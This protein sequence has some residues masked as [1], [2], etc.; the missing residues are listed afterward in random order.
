VTKVEQHDLANLD[1]SFAGLLRI[2]WMLRVPC[3][4]KI[5]PAALSNLIGSIGMSC[6]RNISKNRNAGGTDLDEEKPASILPMSSFVSSVSKVYTAMTIL[7][8]STFSTPFSRKTSS[9]CATQEHSATFGA[10][11]SPWTW[12]SV[13]PCGSSTTVIVLVPSCISNARS[14]TVTISKWTIVRSFVKTYDGVRAIAVK[15]EYRGVEVVKRKA[16]QACRQTLSK[17]IVTT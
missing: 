5:G 7:E 8:T 17:S 6:L 3:H 12:C 9:I 13:R 15:P 14:M 16:V 11:P 4:G 2:S 10:C 1:A